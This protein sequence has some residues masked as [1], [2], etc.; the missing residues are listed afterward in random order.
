MSLEIVFLSKIALSPLSKVIQVIALSSIKFFAAPFL[1]MKHD[2]N[3]IQIFLTVTI[4]GLIGVV[5]F[6][7]LS[8]WLVYSIDK[9]SKLLSA[10]IRKRILRKTEEAEVSKRKI[11]TKKNRLIVKVIRRYGMFGLVVLT[12]VLFTIPLGTFLI[13][14]YF[15]HK[16][17]VVL[18]LS[19]SVIIWALILTTLVTY[20]EF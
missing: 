17:N 3:F 7:V 6:Y 10:F 18:Y 9:Y 19:F 20:F 1:A 8:E 4:G 5:F 12:P 14:R 16:E 11:F 15:S 2:F 13:I